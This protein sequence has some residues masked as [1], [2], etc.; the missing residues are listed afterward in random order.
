M[1]VEL[2]KTVKVSPKGS[3][4]LSFVSAGEVVDIDDVL[5]KKLIKDE[6]AKKV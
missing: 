4:V 1:K 6:V 3:K 2:L 5:A